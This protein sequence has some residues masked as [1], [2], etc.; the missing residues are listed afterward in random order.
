MTPN[1]KEMLPKLQVS[2]MN[3]M[4]TQNL[5]PDVDFENSIAV[6][7]Y[8]LYSESIFVMFLTLPDHELCMRVKSMAKLNEYKRKQGFRLFLEGSSLPALF[9]IIKPSEN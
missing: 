8:W 9:F 2:E 4:F 3:Q 1:S 6:F 7:A 5:W